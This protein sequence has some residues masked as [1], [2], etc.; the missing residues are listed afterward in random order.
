MRVSSTINPLTCLDDDIAVLVIALDGKRKFVPRPSSYKQ[1]HRLILSKF[2]LQDQTKLILHIS[3]L[4]VCAGNDVELTEDVYPLLVPALDIISVTVEGAEKK[5]LRTPAA[6]P[7]I[8]ESEPQNEVT[9]DETV[10]EE[11]EG[12]G[13]D[14]E[15]AHVAA[16]LRNVKQESDDEE[17]FTGSRFG[18]DS[19]GD[20]EA[21][22]VAEDLFPEEKSPVKQEER[23]TKPLRLQQ[24][25]PKK[26]QSRNDDDVSISTPKVRV[27]KQRQ[28]SASPVAGP[29]KSRVANLN[30]SDT[31]ASE[32][33]TSEADRFKI[34]LISGETGK[35]KEFKTRGSHTVEKILSVGAKN[36]GIEPNGGKLVLY[37]LVE[38]TDE[39]GW[40][41]E[42]PARLKCERHQTMQE[43]GAVS[44]SEFVLELEDD[45]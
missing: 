4:D 25:S 12:P 31:T 41:E 2:G 11:D 35:G 45:S 36:L 23:D 40:E 8:T 17:V 18:G 6:T 16:I 7:P 28:R 43:V 19:E 22:R 13:Q 9:G 33:S 24:R 44:G 27:K 21:R 26:A 1:L 15:S 14:N 3:T 38:V 29:S 39:D 42:E 37:L 10:H 20:D 5:G 32:Q 34:T 30:R